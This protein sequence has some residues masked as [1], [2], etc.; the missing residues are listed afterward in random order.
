M[1]YNEKRVPDDMPPEDDATHTGGA[2]ASSATAWPVVEPWQAPRPS[3]CPRLRQCDVWIEEEEEEEEESL[4][5][6]DAK[7]HQ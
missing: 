2:R 4:I 6:G 1:I 5:T 3:G 7:Q